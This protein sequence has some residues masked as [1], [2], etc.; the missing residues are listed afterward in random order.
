MASF[1]TWNGESYVCEWSA[2]AQ[3]PGA[4]RCVLALGDQV[5]D[6]SDSQCYDYP[7]L[8]FIG[9]GFTLTG[10]SALRRQ[11]GQ[12][13]VSLRGVCCVFSL[14]SV[15]GAW[16]QREKAPLA[17]AFF[18][19]RGVVLLRPVKKSAAP[20]CGSAKREGTL[21]H[22]PGFRGAQSSA[23]AGAITFVQ[24]RLSPGGSSGISPQGCISAQSIKARITSS[25][26]APA[27]HQSRTPGASI[28]E[29]PWAAVPLT[30]HGSRG[31]GS[32][33]RLYGA[34]LRPGKKCVSGRTRSG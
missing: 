13:T 16:R 19:S 7:A 15:L 20:G 3:I 28:G 33:H 14:R 23:L 22:L 32:A 4:P 27:G 1:V 9:R 6:C 25:S 10:I 17:R 31:A 2:S 11:G 30:C 34:C 8:L 29:R 12:R 26:A 5:A 18:L 21:K 24:G